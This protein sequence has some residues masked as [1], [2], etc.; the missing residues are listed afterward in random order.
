MKKSRSNSLEILEARIAPAALLPDPTT[1]AGRAK[2]ITP[3]LGLPTLV[4]A[5]EVLSTGGPNSGAYLLYVEKGS[6]LVFFTDLNNNK[7]VDFNELTG[8]AAGNGL[9]MVSFVDIHGDIVTNLKQITVAVPG[10][11]TAVINTLSDSDNNASDD[12]PNLRGDG[13]VVLPSVIEKI[14]MRGLATTDIGDLNGDGVIN[15]ADLV[16]HQAPT[17]SSI[18]GNIYAGG[19]FGTADGKNGLFIDATNDIDFTSGGAADIKPT[20]GSIYTGSAVSGHFFSF[21]AS[22]GSD[23]PN[24]GG[25]IVPFT[26]GRGVPGADINGLH[27]LTAGTPSL[28]LNTLQAGDGGIGAR[29]GNISNVTLPFD[30]SGGYKILAGNGGAGPTGGVGGSIINFSDLGS[31]T[32]HVEITSG[33]GGTGTTGVGGNGG[34]FSFGQFN[35]RGDIFVTQGSG[36]NGFTA[37]GNGA[38]LAKGIITEASAQTAIDAGNAY[39]STHAASGVAYDTNIQIGTHTAISFSPNTSSVGDFVY[40]TEGGT[41]ELVVLLGDGRVMSLPGVRDATALVVA[42]LNGDG[43]PDIAV[44]SSDV[45]SQEGIVTYISQYD[46]KG[47]FLGFDDARY[48]VLPQLSTGDPT[49]G[50]LNYQLQFEFV[51]S[52]QQ[53]VSLTAGDF[54]HNGTI[55]LA[56]VETQYFSH[57]ISNGIVDNLT[58]A[59]QVLLFMTPGTVTDNLKAGH[60]SVLTGQFYV[61]FGTKGVASTTNPIPAIPKAP[62]VDL[63]T[64]FNSPLI[65]AGINNGDGVPSVIMEASPINL[66]DH[67]DSLFIGLKG[68]GAVQTL[69]YNIHD[70]SFSGIIPITKGSYSA[71]AVDSD[72]AI[73]TPMSPHITPENV[74]MQDFSVFDYNGDGT[75]DLAVIS[76]DRF[77]V[78][79]MG[80]GTG[81]GTQTSGGG[82]AVVDQAGLDFGPKINGQGALGLLTSG[83]ILQ[84][85]TGSF[86]FDDASGGSASFSVVDNQDQMGTRITEFVYQEGAEIAGGGPVNEGVSISIGN[87]N[88][89]GALA[90][91]IAFDIRYGNIHNALTGAPTASLLDGEDFFFDTRDIFTPFLHVGLSE[92]AGD[93]GS[94][95]LGRGGN[96][97]NVGSGNLTLPTA[98]QPKVNTRGVANVTADLS[99]TIAGDLFLTAGNGGDGFT[100]GGNGGSVSGVSLRYGSGTASTTSTGVNSDVG[101][102]VE[103]IAGHGGRGVSGPGGN[104]GNISHDSFQTSLPDVGSI[105][106]GGGVLTFSTTLIAGAGGAGNVGGIGG[107]VSGNGTGVFDSVSETISATA[108]AGGDGLHGGGHGG[109]INSYKA[110]LPPPNNVIGNQEFDQNF[111]IYIAGKGGDAVAGPGGAGGSV[112]NDSPAVNAFVQ[113]DV[114]LLA[115]DGGGGT[116][117]GAGG[118]V[119]NFNLLLTAVSKS[120]TELTIHGGL[121][122]HGTTGN[123]GHGGAVVNINTPSR[124]ITSN[125]N[126]VLAGD[127]GDSAGA[128]GGGG[129]SVIDVTTSSAQSSF[130]ITAGAG[131]TGLKHGGTGGNVA[132]VNFGQG[133]SVDNTSAKTL[134][135]AGAGGAA[136]A[137]VAN[138]HDP[139]DHQTE[140]SFGGLIGVGGVGGNI[141]GLTQRGNI[142]GHF[143]LIAGNGGDTPDYGTV[144]D[145]V[146][147]AGN[148]GNI[149]NISIDGDIGNTSDPGAAIKSYNDLQIG[150]SL[151][152]FIDANLRTGTVALNDALGNVGIVVGSGGNAKAQIPNPGGRPDSTSA[153]TSTGKHSGSLIGLSARDLMSAVAG[154]VLDIQPINQVL[155]ISVPNGI[156]GSTKDGEMV[157]PMGVTLGYISDT[158][159]YVHNPVTGGELIDGAVFYHT[160]D[161]SLPSNP[162]VVQG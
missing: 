58:F 71:G 10:G 19:G 137:F 24:V 123:G 28:N 60:P 108:G 91:N 46:A 44:G 43:H 78:G 131:G 25:T 161:G 42:D 159:A 32:S 136:Y 34:S 155:Q 83:Q 48:S 139:S 85:K 147:Y 33:D 38:G 127:G 75:A 51:Q 148:G 37:G 156:I 113:G 99:F 96:G 94:S 124:G 63:S 109:S 52:P 6:A 17:T 95:S 68:K 140:K 103:A 141:N 53:I 88:N 23:S 27:V 122:G 112:N 154:S 47:N 116:T 158:G 111:L 114:D 84:I 162:K 121:G 118:N 110:T 97:G 3:T 86:G 69:Q 92:H 157:D 76:T 143:D 56:V 61:D 22:N 36:G 101:D 90:G 149:L 35:V 41:S 151:A 8:I 72:R 106:G 29:G 55:Q 80:D 16:I 31:T 9:Q 11:Q 102:G 45:G 73:N 89:G 115:G 107:S 133:S 7:E 98:N 26:A 74:A 5:G 135:V 130:A 66:T 138:S 160:T 146:G 82:T 77:V 132:S 79:V 50:D 13:R 39:G 20:I 126:S 67:F 142:A 14:E 59:D 93:G 87:L 117:G 54:Q 49:V 2:Y 152:Q 100:L 125:F 104:G 12:N 144:E 40:T 15:Q 21:G 30:D 134:V 1:A 105:T 4:T 153:T 57:D 81:K 64:Q 65:A 18:F 70:A 62:V 145:K 128:T 150:Q 119:L 120:P 129:G